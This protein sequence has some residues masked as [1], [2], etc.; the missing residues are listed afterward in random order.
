[1]LYE[2]G[3]TIVPVDTEARV[4]EAGSRTK[5]ELAFIAAGLCT[6]DYLD[7]VKLGGLAVRKERPQRLTPDNQFGGNAFNGVGPAHVGI[8]GA[9][10]RARLETQSS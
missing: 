1:M 2:L 5:A 9:I 6:Q 10:E 4:M 8:A 7:D 3:D